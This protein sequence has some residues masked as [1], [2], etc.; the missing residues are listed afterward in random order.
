VQTVEKRTTSTG[1]PYLVLKLDDQLVSFFDEKDQHTSVQPGHQIECNIEL[2]GKYKNGHDLRVVNPAPSNSP[3][4]TTNRPTPPSSL[5]SS[6]PPTTPSPPQKVRI[7][8]DAN[9]RTPLHKLTAAQLEQLYMHLCDTA[10]PAYV[11][12]ISNQIRY[13]R[14]EELLMKLLERHQTS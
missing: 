4:P 10:E 9:G 11:G 7:P 8:V 2:K 13:A 14:L 12:Q 5:N 1:T 3:S 6:S